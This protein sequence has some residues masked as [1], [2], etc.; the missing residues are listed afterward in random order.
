M[1]IFLSALPEGVPDHHHHQ[2]Q[3]LRDGDHLPVR[4]GKRRKDFQYGLHLQTGEGG[5]RVKMPAL[6]QL[7][8]THVFMCHAASE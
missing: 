2:S 1:Q 7:S 4:P 8:L 6:V 5:F 3:V